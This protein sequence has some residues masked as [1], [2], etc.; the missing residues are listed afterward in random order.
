MGG[1]MIDSA[2]EYAEAGHRVFPIWGVREDG[3]CQC[4]DANC[5]SPGKHP[6]GRLVPH[7]LTDA[8]D[9]PETVRSWWRQYPGGNIGLVTGEQFFVVDCD[10]AKEIDGTAL[11]LKLAED[12]GDLPETAC[13]DTGGGGAHF[14]YAMQEGIAVN[15][16][17]GLL[18]EGHRVVGIDVRGSGGYIVAPPSVHASG[19]RYAWKRDLDHLKA[20]PG[21]VQELVSKASFPITVTPDDNLIVRMERGEAVSAEVV[22][23]VADDD[24]EQIK[25]AL[26]F[27]PPNCDRT[28]WIERVSMP[29]HDIFG[30]S[31]EGFEIWHAWCATG[32]GKSTPTGK[33]AYGGEAECR[34]IWRSFHVE[35]RNPKGAA[36][37][38]QYAY[39]C[40]WRP[41]TGNNGRA[42]WPVPGITAS[43]FSEEELAESFGGPRDPGPFPASIAMNLEGP[44]ADLIEWMT[45]AARRPDRTIAFAAALAV[46]AGAI[47][48][49][50]M[51]PEGTRSTLTIAMLAPSGSGKDKPQECIKNLLESHP[52]LSLGLMDD[53]PTH[54]TQLDDLL[55]RNKG[56]ALMVL[57]EYGGTLQRW[58]R[59]SDMASA[60]MSPTIRR[61]ST[62]GATIYHL[63]PVSLRHP[64]RAA[65]V[66]AWD[67]GI[68]APSFSLIGFT[69]PGAFYDSLSDS[70]LTDGFLGRHIVIASDSTANLRTPRASTMAIPSGVR[71]WLQSVEAI[72]VPRTGPPPSFR[73]A[74]PA[75]TAIPPDQP[76][77][78]PQPVGWSHETAETAWTALCAEIDR[79]AHEALASGDETLGAI[80]RRLP[81]QT[82]TLSLI[83]ACGEAR[84][85]DAAEVTE[86]HVDLA[87]RACRWSADNLAWRLRRGVAHDD[88][89]RAYLYA[90]EVIERRSPKPVHRSYLAN[91]AKTGQFVDRL[92]KWFGDDPRFIIEGRAVRSRAEDSDRVT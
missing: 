31:D 67:A 88:L 39:E 15:N 13:A 26:A 68:F 16:Q 43:M 61:L 9:D 21:W 50:I 90:C 74:P 83:L 40:G 23:R 47:G 25:A 7:G 32:A 41:A 58:L 80:L 52:N 72:P 20:A 56:Q 28:T 33:P 87:F 46:I 19:R 1:T 57:D 24:I 53:T 4:P 78:D 27:M 6:H 54:R 79:A 84:T 55:L 59:S 42:S 10:K 37:F 36:T 11:W 70:S 17:Q 18:V 29:L 69:T 51:G 3:S 77:D 12:R 44:I 2:V 86:R 38:W 64:S 5:S 71:L 81:G 49:R 65:N 66:A 63:A 34:K 60:S 85:L 89:S 62:H 76:P 45:E 30:G 82:M 22:P 91:R 35:H 73:P 75:G 14:C 48:R 8:S 92:W